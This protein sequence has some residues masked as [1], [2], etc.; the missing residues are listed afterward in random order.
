LKNIMIVDDSA[1]TRS[2]LATALKAHEGLKIFLTDNVRKAARFF[3]SH[4]VDLLITELQLPEIDGL[5]LLAH[6]RKNYPHTQTIAISENIPDRMIAKLNSMGIASYF[7]KPLSNKNLVDAVLEKLDISIAG[8]IQG[9]A[10]ASFLQLVNIENKTCTLQIVSGSNH[11][12]IHCFQGEIIGAETGE[13]NGYEAFCRIMGW[14]DS[15]IVIK[16]ECCNVE[17][18][19]DIPFMHL[20]METHR[21]LD[22]VGNETRSMSGGGEDGVAAALS[23]NHTGPGICEG[24]PGYAEMEKRFSENPGVV[25]Y[26]IFDSGG[27]ILYS[28]DLS[29]FFSGTSVSQYF[30]IADTLAGLTGSPLKFL[31]MSISDLSNFVLIRSERYFIAAQL[32]PGTGIDELVNC[33]ADIFR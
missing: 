9:V 21:E 3:K 1:K 19:I 26:A 10:L 24:D 6:V 31:T 13:L 22:E 11:G 32:K 16:K 33:Q 18:Q 8:R 23:R 15:D 12:I 2:D 30:S 5:K 4:K 14:D 29:V 25:N 27:R 20:L 7:T 17:R 28:T